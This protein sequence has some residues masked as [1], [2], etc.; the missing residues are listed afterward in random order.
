MGERDYLGFKFSRNFNMRYIL[1]R[2]RISI[3]IHWYILTIRSVSIRKNCYRITS[4]E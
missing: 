3:R 4:S 1:T 2:R